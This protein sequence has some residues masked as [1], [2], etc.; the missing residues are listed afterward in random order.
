MLCQS[1]SH[2][3]IIFIL[4]YLLSFICHSECN[5]ESFYQNY[6]VLKDFLLSGSHRN[7]TIGDFDTIASYF[8]NHSVT[9]LY[10]C[11]SVNVTGLSR[12]IPNRFALGTLD[13]TDF[14]NHYKFNRS[15]S[16]FPSR[17][18]SGSPCDKSMTV[19]GLLSP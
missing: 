6:K 1:L 19:E 12:Y 5:E 9:C 16:P 17:I 4:Y 11:S 3:F 8:V 15:K 14:V 2:P 13:M 10:H 18:I 7:D